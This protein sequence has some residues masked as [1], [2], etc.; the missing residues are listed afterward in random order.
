MTQ[1]LSVSEAIVEWAE[2]AGFK[3]KQGTETADGRVEFTAGLG[4]YRKLV[5]IEGDSWI[6]VNDS[7]R[8]GPEY[9][10]F[11]ASEL[12]ATERYLLDTFGRTIRSRRKLPRIPLPMTAEGVADGFELEPRDLRGEERLA[13]VDS[14]ARVVAFSRGDPTIAV[15]ELVR[16]SHLM[17][18]SVED[19]KASFL[20]PNGSPL[21]SL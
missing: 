17:S 2:I 10:V 4:E 3:T 14:D 19:I 5:G 1:V 13:L 6:I 8:L 21:F 9:V 16:L 11:A 18:A 20:D 15:F 12:E 7:D